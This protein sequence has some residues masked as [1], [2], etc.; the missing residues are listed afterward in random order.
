[1]S[2][3]VLVQPDLVQTGVMPLWQ[4][5]SNLPEATGKLE[6][7]RHRSYHPDETEVELGSKP[8]LADAE[9]MET[10]MQRRLGSRVRDLRIIV[11]QN[12]MIL[13]GRALSFYAK[14]LA[15]HAAMELAALPIL[16][17][18]IQVK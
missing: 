10:Q 9:S 12:G 4:Q 5:V 17:N 7:C 14:Q 6:T 8:K 2:S 18:N 15:Q 1:M 13:Q 11:R 3:F 16:A